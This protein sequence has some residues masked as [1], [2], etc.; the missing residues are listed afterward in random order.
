MEGAAR[1]AQHISPE[2]VSHEA[3]VAVGWIAYAGAVL[4]SSELLFEYAS[5]AL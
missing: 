5:L 4:L 1:A 3:S 2:K